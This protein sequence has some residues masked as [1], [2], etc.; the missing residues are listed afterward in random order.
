MANI[1]LVNGNIQVIFTVGRA[2]D[3]VRCACARNAPEMSADRITATARGTIS[4]RKRRVE[5]TVTG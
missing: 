1:V 5:A 3:G 4:V 2:L